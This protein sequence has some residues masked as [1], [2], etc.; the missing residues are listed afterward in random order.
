MNGSCVL[1]EIQFLIYDFNVLYINTI[2]S[3][4]VDPSIYCLFQLIGFKGFM[5]FRIVC[6]LHISRYILYAYELMQQISD[7]ENA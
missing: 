3:E 2:R 7:G 6:R 1:I 5:L 4:L